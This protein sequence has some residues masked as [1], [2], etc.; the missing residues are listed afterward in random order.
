MRT[1]P[2]MIDCQFACK[3]TRHMGQLALITASHLHIVRQDAFH[4]GEVMRDTDGARIRAHQPFL[5]FCAE[6]QA[7]FW[8]GAAQVGFSD[9]VRGVLNVYSSSDLYNWRFE[10]AAYSSPRSGVD[11]VARPSM[12]GRHP[13]TGRFVMWAKGGGRS[14]Q[15]L[16]ADTPV[17]PFSRVGA[18]DPTVN[19]T[20]GGSQAFRDP[21]S[22]AAALVYSQHRGGPRMLRVL[23]LNPTDW[24]Q[25]SKAQPA[26][27]VGPALR[28]TPAC[29]LEA[30]AH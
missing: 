11:Y 8:Y 19:T 9:G 3:P 13:Q 23:R 4:V 26:S 30:C 14:L 20:A 27:V 18:H 17:G 21:Q 24:T 1:L 10:G 22:A 5:W 25:P 2:F 6:R 15:S 28:C 12:L 16:V 7:Y 29:H